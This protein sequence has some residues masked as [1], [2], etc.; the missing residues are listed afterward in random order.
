MNGIIAQIVIN[1]A[2]N[3]TSFSKTCYRSLLTITTPDCANGNVIVP[4]EVHAVVVSFQYWCRSVS[5]NVP[6]PEVVMARVE[7]KTD[8][9]AVTVVHLSMDFITFVAPISKVLDPVLLELSKALFV[10]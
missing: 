9:D 6:L 3:T 2:V 8:F 7:L 5:L 10:A 4:K 1:M